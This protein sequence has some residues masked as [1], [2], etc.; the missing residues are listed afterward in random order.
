MRDQYNALLNDDVQVVAVGTP[1]L[2]PQAIVISP[3]ANIKTIGPILETTPCNDAPN[4][5]SC[6][7]AIENN[8][9]IAGRNGIA[10]TAAQNQATNVAIRRTAPGA[11]PKEMRHG[12]VS[13][14]SGISMEM[15]LIYSTRPCDT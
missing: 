10:E 3:G 13:Y 9:I 2:A 15:P 6:D 11:I 12:E 1:G 8:N 7:D 4:P 5:A 14:K